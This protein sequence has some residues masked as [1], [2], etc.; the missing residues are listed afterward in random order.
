METSLQSLLG[1]IVYGY[2]IGINIFVCP[3]RQFSIQFEQFSIQFNVHEAR[4]KKELETA[5][6]DAIRKAQD[7]AARQR[8]REANG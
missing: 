1:P 3:C 6:A 2:H 7:E 4:H 5:V 8:V